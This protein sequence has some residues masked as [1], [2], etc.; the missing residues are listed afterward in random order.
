METTKFFE[1]ILGITS[2]YQISEVRQTGSDGIHI[3]ISIDSTYLPMGAEGIHDYEKRTWRHLDLFQYPCYIHCRVP[4]YKYRPSGKKGYVKT[5]EV[6]WS[7]KN[8]GFS[9]LF[10]QSA[11]HLVKLYGTVAKVA[12]QLNIRPQRLWN[13]RWCLK[14]VF[15]LY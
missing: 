4:K 15:L 9:L 14:V 5:L 7:R 13:I 2:P 12:R 3:E 10:E 6:P 11:I 8:S 1:Q